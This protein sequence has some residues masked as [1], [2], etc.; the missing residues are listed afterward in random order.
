M[1]KKIK[2]FALLTVLLCVFAVSALAIEGVQL[3]EGGLHYAKTP[4]RYNSIYNTDFVYLYE[5]DSSADLYTDF[6]FDTYSAA[7]L[8]I[9][10][11]WRLPTQEEMA[12]L[13]DTV[14]HVTSFNID[15]NDPIKCI[16]TGKNGNTLTLDATGTFQ[17][18]S[19]LQNQ[20]I[21]AC[22]ATTGQFLFFDQN[23]SSYEFVPQYYSGRVILVKDPTHDHNYT[24]SSSGDTITATCAGCP[25]ADEAKLRKH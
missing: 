20:G 21:E 9:S 12:Y 18:Q 24:L 15:K 10:D 19:E 11:G 5:V 14:D 3:W 17:S 2:V 25:K 23:S 13:F 7:D 6:N 1:K 4:L 16:I 22:Y 8:G